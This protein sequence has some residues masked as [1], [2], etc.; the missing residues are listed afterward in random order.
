MSSDNRR[1]IAT[2]LRRLFRRG[3]QETEM[4]AEMAFHFEQLVAE[5]EADGMSPAEA[6]R[7][8]HREFGTSEAYREEMRD[9]WRP[10]ALS[11]LLRGLNHALRSLARTPG[12]TVVAIVTIAL[13]AGANTTMFSILNE[14]ALRPLPYPQSTELAQ[15]YRAT[16]QNPRSRNSPADWADL[17]REAA[18]V[19]EVTG[20]H[21]Q[22]V[23]I[24]EPGSN[25]II[26]RAYRVST[27]FFSVYRMQPFMGRDFRP[28]EEILG[29]HRVVILSHAFWQR[30]FGGRED[31][32]GRTL[33]LQGEEHEIIGVM[34]SEFTDW[35]VQG[36]LDLYR[37][38]GLTAAEKADRSSTHY[39]V[40]TRPL[41]GHT[42]AEVAAFVASFGERRATDYP[43][44][45]SGTVWR[46]VPQEELKIGDGLIALVMLIGLSGFVLLIACSNLANLLL[47]R[48]IARSREFALRSALGASRGQLLRPLLTESMLLAIG[49]GVLAILVCMWGTDMLRVLSTNDHGDQ[50]TFQIDWPVMGWALGA[51]MITALGFSLAPAWHALRLD[52]NHVLKTGGMHSTGGRGQQRL[53]HVLIIGQ[54]A[55]AMVLLTGAAMFITGLRDLNNRQEGWS[56]DHLTTAF[57]LLPEANYREP[58]Q[59]VALQDRVLERLGALPGVESASVSHTLP[60]FGLS[61]ARRLAI[62]GQPPAEPGQELRAATNGVSNDYFATMQTRLQR[63]RTFTTHDQRGDQPVFIVNQQLADTLF[64]GEEVL[65]RRIAY[66]TEDEPQWGE[67]V[68]VVANVKSVFPESQPITL[69]IY[70]PI[71]QEPEAYNEFAV[72]TVGPPPADL[73]EQIRGVIAK[74]D[75]DLPVSYLQPAAQ[76]IERANYQAGVFGKILTGF[77]VLG[78]ALATLGI[79]GI[80]ARL[81]AQRT[82]EFGI[83]IALGAQMRDITRQVLG[84]GL[85]LSLG[86][87]AIGMLGAWGL[88]RLFHAVFP[89]MRMVVAP[90]V[91]GS[92]L[93]LV[94]VALL[95]CYLPARRAALT[96]P[97]EALRAE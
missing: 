96:H 5:F 63:G 32:V 76:R 79:Y 93:L 74:I 91:L 88:V 70:H 38:L 8:A 12:F 39:N 16:P 69:Q 44:L 31:I 27:N 40:T 46:S 78:L 95:A 23:N 48:T 80:I 7:A 14:M 37:P 60:F 52:L 11:D 20:Y 28:E 86:G 92:G 97:A 47:A 81:V 34:P 84:S 61:S 13:G 18:D 21:Y 3:K 36:V 62:A 77:A 55:L 42:A 66:Q 35:R 65:G 6:R 72:R 82:A 51:A 68:G 71:G 43:E 56:S 59:I 1:W 10:P 49:G 22:D 75:P 94:A 58:E 41:A 19:A 29:Q 73:A 33:R 53:R 17:R 9:S 30:Q 25:A 89:G 64:D 54:F 57:V 2:L 24:A 26:A 90:V 45:H 50:M 67:I 83:R 4:E 85:K 15:V 87:G